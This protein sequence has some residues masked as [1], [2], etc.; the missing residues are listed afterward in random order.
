MDSKKHAQTPLSKVPA[1]DLPGRH[2]SLLAPRD[3]LANVA[4]ADLLRRVYRRLQWRPY[5]LW[6]VHCPPAWWRC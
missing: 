5:A 6:P 1:S 4:A 2:R 3:A